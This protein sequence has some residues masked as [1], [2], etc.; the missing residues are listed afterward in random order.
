MSNSWAPVALAVIQ[1]QGNRSS[2]NVY[3]I[4][5]ESSR[6]SCPIS[7]HANRQQVLHHH[8]QGKTSVSGH[9]SQIESAKCLYRVFFSATVGAG[10]GACPYVRI[11]ILPVT[12][13]EIK[14]VRYSCNKI[15]NRSGSSYDSNLAPTGIGLPLRNSA[16]GIRLFPGH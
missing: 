12:T 13:S 9:L 11:S 16:Q 2:R 5:N 4:L 7:I 6:H 3:E 1:T 14:A 8:I 10:T 15:S